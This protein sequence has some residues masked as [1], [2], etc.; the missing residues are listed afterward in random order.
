LEINRERTAADLGVRI[1]DVSQALNTLG[2]R[3]GSDD[4]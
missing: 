1:G 4:F 2:R 3:T